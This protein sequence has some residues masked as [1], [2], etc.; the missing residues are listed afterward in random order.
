MD[1]VIIF[2]NILPG[3]RISTAVSPEYQQFLK[4]NSG[5]KIAVTLTVISDKGNIRQK[6]Y[7]EKVVLPCIIEGFRETGEITNKKDADEWA[8]AIC[9][10]TNK[11]KKVR[12]EWV[13]D[14]VPE[15]Q[16]TEKQWSELIVNSIRICAMEFMIIVPE[17][18]KR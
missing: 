15:N 12:G 8:K 3:G 4:E 18:E 16:M 13:D 9:P 6:T 14:I 17:P 11:R 5:E 1:E 10:A 2:G 7:Y